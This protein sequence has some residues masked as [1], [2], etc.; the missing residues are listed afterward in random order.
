MNRRKFIELL[1]LYIDGEVDPEDVG[2]LE[3]KISGDAEARK[4]Y[5]EYCQ[6]YR[7]SRMVYERFRLQAPPEIVTDRRRITLW[8]WFSARRLGGLTIAAGGVAAAIILVS[9]SLFLMH[10]GGDIE[11]M[12]EIVLNPAHNPEVSSR[13]TVAPV[14]ETFNADTDIFELLPASDGTLVPAQLSVAWNPE[15]NLRG[16]FLDRPLTPALWPTFDNNQWETGTQITY[17]LNAPVQSDYR[18]Y[19]GLDSSSR[20][21]SS[22][23]PVDFQFPK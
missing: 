8:D 4:T 7:G 21:T 11:T 5:N 13:V 19:R 14:I 22:Y 18:V 1:N 17:P 12:E 15:I 16:E 10:P 9:G 23:Q 3:Q 2:R 20:R 6:L